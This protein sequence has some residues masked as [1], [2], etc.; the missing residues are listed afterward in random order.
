MKILFRTKI[1]PFVFE[2]Y[3]HTLNFKILQF[4]SNKTLSCQV[5]TKG[6]TTK[7]YFDSETKPLGKLKNESRKPL[8][9]LLLSKNE[10]W[11]RSFST[12]DAGHRTYQMWMMCI[13]KKQTGYKPHTIIHGFSPHPDR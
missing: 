2:K 4:D 13:C 12:A 10:I 1:T 9:P 3:R 6:K 8:P 7:L 11:V 5:Y